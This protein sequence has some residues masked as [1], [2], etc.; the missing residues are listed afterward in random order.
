MVKS[1]REAEM[2]LTLR[3]PAELID[4]PTAGPV[5]RDYYT[6][7]FNG[8]RATG[9]T[10]PRD[11]SARAD[12]EIILARRP[13]KYNGAKRAPTADLHNDDQVYTHRLKSIKRP[14]STFV[15]S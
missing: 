4:N 7:L 2:L 11:S 9:N 3:V 15:P 6:R 1:Q 10:T 14:D 8:W 13:V 5:L 12:Y